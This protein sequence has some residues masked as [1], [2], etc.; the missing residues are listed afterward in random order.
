MGS[1][2][3]RNVAPEVFGPDRTEAGKKFFDWIN[4]GAGRLVVGGK[5]IKELAST[6]AGEW[7][8][9]A[10]L[11]KRVKILDKAKVNT[12]VN[13]LQDEGGF[14][15]DDPHIV[16]LAQV[17]GARLLYSNDK[18]LQQDFKNKKLIDQP[19]GKVYSTISGGGKFEDS[20]K[21]LL[22]L[23]KKDLCEVPQ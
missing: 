1:I 16:A 5:L 10:I 7:V 20:H 14:K 6:K 11:S 13:K 3:D 12:S 17:S 8:K 23:K 19:R 21:R 15:S 4:A 22:R 9:Q 18:K 2:L